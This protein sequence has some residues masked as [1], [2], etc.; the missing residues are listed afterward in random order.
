MREL[1]FLREMLK[2]GRERDYAEPRRDQRGPG[3]GD[4]RF[5]D[6]YDRRGGRDD[7]GMREDRFGRGPRD[8]R[9]DPRD[10]VDR[11]DRSG[12]SHFRDIRDQP[13]GF[14]RRDPVLP[15]Y[16]ERNRRPLSQDR[17]IS[18]RD[19]ARRGD[20]RGD[21]RGEPQPVSNFRDYDDG[22]DVPLDGP[23]DA[24]QHTRPESGRGDIRDRLKGSRDPRDIAR[25]AAAR[26]AMRHVNPR[27][28]DTIPGDGFR[29]V[30]PAKENGSKEYRPQRTDKTMKR[31]D[32]TTIPTV[33]PPLSRDDYK[34][35]QKTESEVGR[36]FEENSNNFVQVFYILPANVEKLVGRTNA[37]IHLLERKY[38]VALSTHATGRVVVRA[39]RLTNVE[40]CSAEVRRITTLWEDHDSTDKWLEVTDQVT[41][42]LERNSCRYMYD[43]SR[44]SECKIDITRR[45]TG[46]TLRMSGT[47]EARAAGISELREFVAQSATNVNQTFMFPLD[48]L[49]RFIG[50]RGRNL[51][52]F[53]RE[54]E[55]AVNTRNAKSE[56]VGDLGPLVLTAPVAVIA[57][58]KEKIYAQ[59]KA[60]KYDLPKQPG[61]EEGDLDVLGAP[62]GLTLTRFEKDTDMISAEEAQRALRYSYLRHIVHA[63]N[64]EDPS[65]ET[66][67]KCDE[68]VAH[69]EELMIAASYKPFRIR[70]VG[71]WML[72]VA[73]KETPVNMVVVQSKKL[74][75]MAPSMQAEILAKLQQVLA[76]DGF[77]SVDIVGLYNSI[78]LRKR[79]GDV[80]AA[81]LNAQFNF[82]ISC[83]AAHEQQLCALLQAYVQQSPAVRGMMWVLSSF[84]KS[85]PLAVCSTKVKTALRLETIGVMVIRFLL[86]SSE[87]KW[88]DPTSGPI[89]AA[90]EK[91]PSECEWE[92]MTDISQYK[93]QVQA[94]MKFYTFGFDFET[95][96][97]S[98]TQAQSS[99]RDE[100]VCPCLSATPRGGQ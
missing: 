91:R 13:S 71:E 84:F 12:P 45:K 8:D 5:S 15:D 96:Q 11:Y 31:P 58:A 32:G 17:F 52:S 98:I 63:E 64:W 42:D 79:G 30:R 19:S 61:S 44:I 88:I 24:P 10:R 7:R 66:L 77:T 40:S 43:I 85:L 70:M 41:L 90:R 60:W 53:E 95:H 48:A 97:V 49:D 100:K 94:F 69:I 20:P 57:K 27:D 16:R 78:F 38:S 72:G 37:Q 21:P 36:F 25:D 14:S 6:R 83:N 89:T 59:L 1:Q 80:T 51:A 65:A 75:E 92:P 26:D 68:L 47:P 4:D 87:L 62:H 73:D 76:K 54:T 99:E 28:S 55:C 74:R 86:D 34:Q 39:R 81:S 23:P 46:N 9:A 18:P 50:Q 93:S 3:R 56:S 29:E 82:D 35:E 22:P 33:V 67:K 2:G